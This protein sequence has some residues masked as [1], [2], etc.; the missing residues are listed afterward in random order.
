MEVIVDT[1]MA[2]L[3]GLCAGAINIAS[4][5]PQLWQLIKMNRPVGAPPYLRWTVGTRARPWRWWGASKLCA[6]VRGRL[7]QLLANLLWLAYATWYGLAS[8]QWTATVMSACV[9]LLAWRLHVN[10]KKRLHG[11]ESVHGCETD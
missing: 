5:G 11:S 8:L 10:D 7:I 6:E 9:A 1:M 3:V 4:T 2:D